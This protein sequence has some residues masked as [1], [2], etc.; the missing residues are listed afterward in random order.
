MNPAKKKSWQG[1]RQ[2]TIRILM[3][4]VFLYQ[5]NCKIVFL[6]TIYYKSLFLL[7][8]QRTEY[9]AE[10]GNIKGFKEIKKTIKHTK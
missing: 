6:T 10:C 1:F 8:F 4:F 5:K 3:M 9:K 2:R 7:C